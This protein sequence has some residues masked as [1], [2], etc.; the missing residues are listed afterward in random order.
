M[1]IPD[2]CFIETIRRA[3]GSKRVLV[4]VAN[5]GGQSRQATIVNASKPEWLDIE[6][7]MMGDTLSFKKGGKLPLVINI[8]TDHRFFPTQA[9]VREEVKLEF[10]DGEA[11][12]IFLNIQEIISTVQ[13]FRGTFAMDFGTTNTCYA[14][15]ERVGDNIQMLDLVK[16]PQASRELPTLVRYKDIS[17]RALPLVEIGH[18]ARDFIA[19][20]SG[21][22]YSYVISIKRSLGLDSALVILDDRSG[23]EANRYQRYS[24]EEVAAHI[25][26]EILREAEGR[27]GQRIEQVVATFPI[28]YNAKKIAALRKAFRLAFEMLNREWRD[29]RLILRLDETNAAAFN[30][31]YGQLLDEFRR[32][33][34]QARQHRLLSYDFGGGTVDVSLVDVDLTRDQ[35]GRISITTRM[36]G[37]TGDRYFAGDIVTLAV[38]K[39]LKLRLASKVASLRIAAI[40]RARKEQEGAS[41]QAAAAAN[42]W[43]ISVTVAKPA[44]TGGDPWA[45]M[46]AEEANKPAAE[47]PVE[48]EENP[49]TA[50]IENLTP[51]ARQ[52][53][54]WAILHSNPDVIDT[55]AAQGLTAVAA[56]QRLV[57]DGSKR[58]SPL[59]INELAQGIDEAVDLIIPTRWKTLEEAGDL[60]SKE[61]ARK[62]F[63]EMW[64][65]AEV[66]KIKAVTD[67]SRQAALTEPL[68][69]VAK[70]AGVRPDALSGVVV[71]EAE[72][73]AAIDLP[74]RR[75]IG[76]AAHL[77]KTA[78]E[79]G[80]TSSGGLSFGGLSMGT[81]PERPVT[82]LL[83]GNSARLPIVRRLVSEICQIDDQ[84]VVMDPN[85]LKA[86]VAQGA[87]EEHILRKDFGG[88]LIKYDAGDFLDRIPYAIGLF[89]KELTL[90]G[91][92]GGF[93]PVM[94]R[95][96]AVDS[97]VLLTESLQVI[98]A[99]AKDLTIFAYYH[100]HELGLDP[101][102]A[103]PMATV[104]PYN[105]G[106]FDLNAPEPTPWTG[107]F[108]AE[109]KAQI[110]A[111]GKGFGLVLVLDRNRDLTLVQPV[112]K[113]QF[114]LKA[115]REVYD[116]QEN[117]FSGVH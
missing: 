53:A 93:A 7:A 9:N 86:T 54:A 52:E 41:Q 112:D 73:N 10:N 103:G 65:P 56:V 71:T 108:T 66:I 19:H 87:C 37:I 78:S 106:W 105:L 25:I 111:L 59:E 20:N 98:H 117:P 94:P 26:K 91:F 3:S 16:P 44:A 15:K 49:E 34:V 61:S 27:I 77:L 24:P 83:A 101:A 36:L 104:Q 33:A 55:M 95:G 79:S 64:L 116:D 22:N 96:T 68:H 23:L 43:A 28:L 85:G 18:H 14:W 67:P 50:D 84:R 58:L 35:T 63:Y 31:V 29:D 74:L 38:V 100:D 92:A 97:Q 89:N 76:K 5:A 48:E 12:T 47:A 42:P 102:S 32:F 46:A 70:Y 30:Y 81:A 1:L 51:V 72:I 57:A 69:K 6:G 88:G 110:E 114:K 40:E 60:I 107:E 4:H 109:V 17:N 62:L 113:K 39:L 45:A 75:S 11:L 90:L 13:S 21:R 8:N 80:G 115:S 99:N 82:I 2:P